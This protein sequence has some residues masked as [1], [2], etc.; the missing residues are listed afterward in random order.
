MGTSGH[1][2]DSGLPEGHPEQG[3]SRYILKDVLGLPLCGWAGGEAK[4]CAKGSAA[5]AGAAV[6]H[7]VLNFGTF[8]VPLLLS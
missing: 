3:E 8:L 6:G 7:A 5:S 2:W 4:G 1:W